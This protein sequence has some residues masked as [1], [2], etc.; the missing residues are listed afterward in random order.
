MTYDINEDPYIDKTTGILKNKIGAKTQAALDKTEAEITYVIIATLTVGSSVNSLTFDSQLLCDIHQEIFGDI[1]RWAGKLRTHD[2]RKQSE[3]F[4]HAKFIRQELAR[5][6]AELAA[7]DTKQ[8]RDVSIFV[9]HIAYFYGEYNAIHP[10]REGN[11][12]ALRTFLRLYALKFGY[13]IDWSRMNPDENIRA[14]K[15]S[16]KRNLKPL[17]VMLGR[18]IAAVDV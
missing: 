3:Y 14:S 13:D 15:E 16:V 18:L 8:Y 5:I 7:E 9:R 17:E 1:Y 4:C 12:R 11:G 2:I 6:D 10:F